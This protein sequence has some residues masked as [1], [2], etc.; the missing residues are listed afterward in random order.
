MD[1]RLVS[2]SIVF[3]LVAGGV[4]LPIAVCVC[5]AIGTLLQAMGDTVGSAVLTYIAWG[6]GGLWGLD[7]ICLVLAA[8]INSLGDKDPPSE[9]E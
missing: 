1:Q 9:S 4:A 6:C 8:G 7:L 3:F 5:L 2:K